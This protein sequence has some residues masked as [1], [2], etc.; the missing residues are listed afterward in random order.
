LNGV[1]SWFCGGVFPVHFGGSSLVFLVVYFHDCA[2]YFG[3]GVTSLKVHTFHTGH[4]GMG[5]KCVMPS[6]HCCGSMLLS[7]QGH[8]TLTVVSA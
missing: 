4:V 8:Y 2:L 1:C 7:H 6:A 3:F 5:V